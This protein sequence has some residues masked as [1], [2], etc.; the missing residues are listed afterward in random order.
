MVYLEAGQAGDALEILR[1]AGVNCARLRLFTSTEAQALADPYNRA[2]NLAYT[3]P[4]AV[5]VKQAGLRFLLDF[6][7][8]DICVDSPCRMETVD[9]CGGFAFKERRMHPQSWIS[10]DDKGTRHCHRKHSPAVARWRRGRCSTP[11]R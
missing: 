3:I 1:R 7:Y 4:L 11:S 9:R 6:H 8:S 10:K 5:R 2:N